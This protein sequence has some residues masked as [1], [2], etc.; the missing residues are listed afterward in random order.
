MATI[1]K[2]L[3]HFNKLSDFELR[4]QAGDI[5]S[6]SIVFI[7][8]AKKIWTHGEYYSNLD[9]VLKVTEQSLT[10]EQQAQVKY[11]LGITEEVTIG[12]SLPEILPDLFVDTSRNYEEILGGGIEEAPSDGNLYARKNKAWELINSLDAKSLPILEEIGFIFEN[13]EA[14]EEQYNKIVSFY[15]ENK[16]GDDSEEYAYAS[17]FSSGVI[18]TAIMSEYKNDIY[19]DINGYLYSAAQYIQIILYHDY[20]VVLDYYNDSNIFGDNS[21]LSIENET[22]E[23]GRSLY[24]ETIGESEGIG[25]GIGFNSEKGY[26]YASLQT[27]GE[28]E[29]IGIGFESEKGYNYVS[30]KTN[31]DGTKVLADNGEYIEL[32]QEDTEE[33]VGT[34]YIEGYSESN[35][36]T[37]QVSSS[38][39][40]NADIVGDFITAIKSKR[41]NLNFITPGLYRL[42]IELSRS[43]YGNYQADVLIKKLDPAPSSVTSCMS[44][45]VASCDL[46]GGYDVYISYFNGT[47]AKKVRRDS[48]LFSFEEINSDPFNKYGLGILTQNTFEGLQVYAET[49][50]SNYRDGY[51]NLLYGTEVNKYAYR[52]EYTRDEYDIS[53]D[54]IGSEV[55]IYNANRTKKI[56]KVGENGV[57]EANLIAPVSNNTTSFDMY[58]L[59]GYLYL[60]ANTSGFTISNNKGVTKTVFFVIENDGTSE[61]STSINGTQ[62]TIGAGEKIVIEVTSTHKDIFISKKYVN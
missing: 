56:C 21:S 51:I 39:D 45:T 32:K 34:P 55:I 16:I 59:C 15:N 48:S 60:K 61:V 36:L 7:K 8:D 41:L 19:I 22:M 2:K 29:G 1:N 43:V 42:P 14:T 18:C 49:L 37:V 13:G 4:L 62:L 31:G 10:A 53:F 28:S 47:I 27:I 3:V 30:L 54:T 52:K 26:N 57:S 9:D 46:F 35:R 17:F 33:N 12:D 24:L 25:I 44:S 38:E 11:N 40:Y 20:S 58:M 5:L 6:H 23:G 50:I